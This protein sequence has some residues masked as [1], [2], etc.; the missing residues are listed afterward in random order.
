MARRDRC[1]GHGV[2]H[3]VVNRGIAKR[4]CFETRRDIRKFLAELARAVRRGEVELLAYCILTTHFHLVLRSPLGRLSEG[5]RRAQNTFVRHFNRL[6]RRDGP[7]FRG[8]FWS[9]P[10]QSDAYL[11]LLIRYVDHNS[12]EARLVERSD[13][14]PWGS[15][16]HYTRGDGPRWLSRGVV[17]GL[18]TSAFA[19]GRYT[20]ERYVELFGRPVTSAQADLVERRFRLRVAGLDPL[21]DLLTAA[22]SAV[23]E[24][25]TRKAKLADGTRPGVPIADPASMLSSV[26]AERACDP[27]WRVKPRRN[28]VVGWDVLAA[29]LLR[30]H[31]GCTYHEVV[32]RTGVT[33][34]TAR[35]RLRAHHDLL[36]ADEGYAGRAADVLQR[37]VRTTLQ[38][39]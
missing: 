23:L 12:P 26:A 6:R 5:M 15:A 34:R 28:R 7:L 9:R 17:E 27:D 19:D 1:D 10:V 25:M 14:Y 30:L 31:T 21:D 11:R 18:V 13:A 38:G 39:A 37:A 22:P 2:M 16:W 8:R 32:A 33:S 36:L 20:P 24:W 29:G 4:T 35:D 3:H